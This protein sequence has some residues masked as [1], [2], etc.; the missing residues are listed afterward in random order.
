MNCRQNVVVAHDYSSKRIIRVQNAYYGLLTCALKL[1]NTARKIDTVRIYIAIVC[2]RI[3]YCQ[4]S[5]KTENFCMNKIP[6]I[7][8][9]VLENLYH[10]FEHKN[11][12]S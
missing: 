8:T 1:T 10:L 3:A 2:R 6:T 5:R 12:F 9:I 7:H 4:Y 11:S